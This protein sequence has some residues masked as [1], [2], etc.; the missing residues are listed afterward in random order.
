MIITHIN[1]SQNGLRVDKFLCQKFDISFGTAQKLLR[2]KKIKVNDKKVD[3]SYKIQDGDE[4]KIFDDLS[5]RLN[6]TKKKPKISPQKIE[7]FLS[8]II[9]K[10]ENIVAINKPAQLAV[11]GGSG[12]NVSV[13][14]MLDCLL[15]QTDQNERPQLVHRLDKDTSGV[16]L[17]ALNKK[18]AEH[19]T[20]L[21]KD[22]TITKT[23]LAMVDGIVKKDSGEINIALRKKFVGKNEKVYPDKE[24][25]EAITKYKL[26]K[27]YADCS[28]LELKPL[29]GRTHQL[30]VHC[31]EIGHPIINDIKYGGLKVARK[32]LTENLCLHAWK[33]EFIDVNGKKVLIEARCPRVLG[34]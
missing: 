26:L 12:I 18:T 28:L 20:K 9:Y 30:R 32:N 5:N 29:T 10:D 31:K 24:G 34:C 15:K 19:L 33:I 25:K 11:Q 14:D 17:I 21:F 4:I 8:Y 2:E 13:D 22:K 27:T 3:G 6:K 16:L 7:K 1:Q 23:Y